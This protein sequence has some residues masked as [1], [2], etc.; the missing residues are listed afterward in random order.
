MPPDVAGLS[1]TWRDVY[2]I[3][4]RYKAK[5]CGPDAK[6]WIEQFRIVSRRRKTTASEHLED[7]GSADPFANINFLK[8]AFM[9]ACHRSGLMA[10]IEKY[11]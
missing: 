1:N 10:T 8:K 11:G 5:F 9:L 7:I 4:E 6:D 3:D 2:G